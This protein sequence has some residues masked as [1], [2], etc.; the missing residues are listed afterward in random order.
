MSLLFWAFI[1]LGLLKLSWTSEPH[2]LSLLALISPLLVFSSLL[3]TIMGQIH[4]DIFF[5]AKV[6]R[7]VKSTIQLFSIFEVLLTE[8][9]Y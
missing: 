7:T 6:K 5:K 1:S 8:M 9:C 3:D 4:Y 2:I